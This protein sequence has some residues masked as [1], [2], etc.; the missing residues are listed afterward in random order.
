MSIVTSTAIRE[1]YRGWVR[2]QNGPVEPVEDE[3]WRV[4]ILT[5]PDDSAYRAVVVREARSRHRLRRVLP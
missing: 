4:R 1:A 3:H 2:N 5:E